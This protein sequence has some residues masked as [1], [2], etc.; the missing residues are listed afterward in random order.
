VASCVTLWFSSKSFVRSLLVRSSISVLILEARSAFSACNW[1]VLVS[2]CFRASLSSAIWD[3]NNR[4]LSSTWREESLRRKEKGGNVEKE[5]LI[6]REQQQVESPPSRRVVGRAVHSFAGRHCIPLGSE[7]KRTGTSWNHEAGSQGLQFCFHTVTRERP[8]LP[9]FW[10][11][12]SS[13]S[14][15]KA[16]R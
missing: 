11:L 2:L 6:C 13:G 4:D 1:A 12:F 10:P 16:R 5:R 14:S 15:K 3:C 9:E 7:R 8:G